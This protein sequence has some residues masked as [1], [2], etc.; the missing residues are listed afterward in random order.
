MTVC[1]EHLDF[2]SVF[3]LDIVAGFHGGDIISGGGGLLVK[4]AGLRGQITEKAAN[5]LSETRQPGKVD[6][7]RPACAKI[8]LEKML[9]GMLN[10]VP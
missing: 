3:N 7:C 9:Q 1:R 5:V 6:H 2:A 10:G 4:E 8:S